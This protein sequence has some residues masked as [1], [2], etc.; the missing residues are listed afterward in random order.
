M[1]YVKWL[2]GGLGWALGGPIGAIIGFVIGSVLDGP[3]NNVFAYDDGRE[4]QT[5]PHDFK[6]SLLI[7][8]AAVI[9]AD[10][11]VMKSELD[12]VRSFLLKQ[13]GEGEIQEHMLF[14]RDVLKQ[15]IDVEKV[16]L[17]IKDYMDYSSRLQ[18]LHFLFGISLAD[19]FVHPN[20]VDLISKIASYLGIGSSDFYS[21]KAM[22][23][24]DEES[25]YKILG[26][27]HDATDEEIKKAYRMMAL[28]YHPDKVSHLGEDVKKAALEKFQELN[29]SYQ[30]IKKIRGFL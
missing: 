20:E 27:S 25:T 16:S 24:K 8:L 30:K 7:L 10:G 17:Q 29:N 2:G 23:I 3:G 12:Y 5:S 15:D 4:T 13:F 21:V 14:I 26:V 1:K 19:G 18:L 6:L 11:K 28:K 22:F 9:K